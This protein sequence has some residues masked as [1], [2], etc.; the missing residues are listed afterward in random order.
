MR[1]HRA[2]SLPRGEITVYFVLRELQTKVREKF[3]MPRPACLNTAEADE[4]RQRGKFGRSI[5]PGFDDQLR[6][7][8]ERQSFSRSIWKKGLFY[9]SERDMIG[10]P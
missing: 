4:G 3:E 9:E 2:V 5:T 7:G 1:N 10:F 6:N 8:P